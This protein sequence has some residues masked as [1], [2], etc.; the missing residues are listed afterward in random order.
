MRR[1]V[2]A[3]G[4]AVLIT[5]ATACSS[6]DSADGPPVL[7]PG[8]PGESASPAS[9]EQIDA[10]SETIRHNEADVEYV[11]MM[12][13]HHG[14]AITMTDLVEGRLENDDLALI[15]DRISAAQGPEIEAME[16][17]LDTNVYGPAEENP[18][19]QGFCANGPSEEGHH[20]GEGD[21]PVN[22]DHDDMPGMASEEE[23]TEL[24]EADGADI[25]ELFVELMT[26]HHEGAISMAEDEGADGKHPDALKMAADVMVEQQADINRMAEVMD[27]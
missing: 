5:G 26:A 4:A 13:E 2:L 18:N 7:A 1:W 10:A 23:L 21:C 9:Q 24:E 17:W 20:G 12:I 16:G 11:L 8:A 6:S 19:H 22:L 14:Q 27:Q 15:A 3:A 25:D